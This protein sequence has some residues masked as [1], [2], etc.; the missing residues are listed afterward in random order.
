MEQLLKEGMA[1]EDWNRI[2]PEILN[3]IS[4]EVHVWKLVRDSQGKIQTW[5]LVYA[6]AIALSSWDK[7]L[8]SIQGLTTQEIFVNADPIG[9]FMP[10]VERIFAE[11]KPFTWEEYFSGTNQTLAMSSIPVGEYF[12]SIGS[13]ISA[14]RETEN[15]VSQAHRLNSLGA[16]AGGVVHDVNNLLTIIQANA[17]IL[18]DCDLES[19]VKFRTQA[20]VNACDRATELLGF[21]LNFSKGGE[22]EKD[23][24]LNL[25]IANVIKLLKPALKKNIQLL[26]QERHDLPKVRG[27][28]IQITQVLFNIATNALRAMGDDG[29][30]LEFSTDVVDVSQEQIPNEFT[31]VRP[32][33]FVKVSVRDRGPGMDSG[34]LKHIFKPFFTR[35][36]DGKGSGLGLSIVK[37]ITEKHHGF[38]TVESQLGVGS[39]FHV[40]FPVK[41]P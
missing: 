1:L 3:N 19:D 6:N 21:I 12:I 9:L 37:S 18:S 17:M 22:A 15:F 29:G 4:N 36:R 20:I 41:K 30:E 25:K 26:F 11:Q 13:D 2:Y 14:K 10:I 34:I 33:L 38:V 5:R 35:S 7:E 24:D 16:I 27:N 28:H 23:I 40:Y 8:S 31:D 32:G 39:T